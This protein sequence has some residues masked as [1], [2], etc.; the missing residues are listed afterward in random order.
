MAVAAETDERINGDNCAPW[1][2]LS[3]AG[4]PRRGRRGR[5]EG[6]FTFA[7]TPPSPT[8]PLLPSPPVRPCPLSMYPLCQLEIAGKVLSFYLYKIQL[9]IAR[10]IF[11]QIFLSNILGHY[12]PLKTLCYWGL[13][14][15]LWVFGPLLAIWTLWPV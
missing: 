10:Q 13:S 9:Y 14:E 2:Q 3:G 6:E 12:G 11:W 1:D 7:S 8:F 5:G 4:W 15:P